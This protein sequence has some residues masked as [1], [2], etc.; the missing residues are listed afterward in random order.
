MG[1]SGVNNCHPTKSDILK[2]TLYTIGV[3]AIAVGILGAHGFLGRHLHHFMHATLPK[4]IPFQYWPALGAAPFMAGLT[5]KAVADVFKHK[6]G[7]S[8]RI[9]PAGP[10]PLEI[11]LNE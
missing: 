1:I 10:D 4:A 5:V 7:T 11:N 3:A 9:V 8:R 6:S 2:D